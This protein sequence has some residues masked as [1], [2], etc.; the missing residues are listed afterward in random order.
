MKHI[1]TRTQA[2]STIVQLKEGVR[3]INLFAPVDAN[4]KL[5]RLSN[6]ELEQKLL[7]HLDEETLAGVVEEVI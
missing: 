4:H 5:F 7:E 3:E 2:V 1:F 6:D